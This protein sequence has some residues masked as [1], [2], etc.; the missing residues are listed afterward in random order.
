MANNEVYIRRLVPRKAQIGSAG[1]FD[2]LGCGGQ[3]TRPPQSTDTLAG[4]EHQ[5]EED[6]NWRIVAVV[7]VVVVVVVVRLLRE[8]E[9]CG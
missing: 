6:L 5:A 9:D 1:K 2:Y 8:M 3:T 4:S 7:V